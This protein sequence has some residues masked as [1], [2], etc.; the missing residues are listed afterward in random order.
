[1]TLRKRL[2]LNGGL[3]L[4][5]LV[6]ILY[7]VV[8]SIISSGFAELETQTI[9]R[10]VQ[11]VLK[12]VDATQATLNASDRDYA[13]WDDMY[14]F[15]QDG[16]AEF[17]TNNLTD[18]VFDNL[19]LNIIAVVKP[20]AEV[21]Y[22]RSY[23]LTTQSD[24]AVPE[25]LLAHLTVNDRLLAPGTPDG[26]LTGLMALPEGALLIVSHPIL[27]S[28]G[29]GPGAGML[30]MGRYLNVAEIQR[31]AETT[32]LSI[33]TY[34][35]ASPQLPQPVESIKASLS[36][37]A[38]GATRALDAETIAGYSLLTDL[39]NQPALIVQVSEARTIYQRGQASLN[40]VV[41]ALLVAGL[42]LG[43]A[44][45][46]LLDKIVL[47]RVS[48][49]STAI[50]RLDAERDLSV[51]APISGRD[52][53]SGLAISFNSMAAQLEQSV[54]TLE[55][56]V[57]LQ[58]AQLQAGAEVGRAATSILDPDRLLK[59][60]MTLITERFGFYYAAAFVLDEAGQ[61][62][63]LREASGPGD[64]A[65]LLKQSS[66]KLEIGGR[67]MISTAVTTRHPRI[68]LDV[69]TEAVR[70]ANPLLPDTRSEIALPL[71]VGDQVL[72]ALDVQSTQP[73]AFDASSAAV[74]QGMADQIAVAINNAAQY[75]RAQARTEQIAGLLAAS[76]E[77]SGQP[78]QIKL[79]ERVEDVSSSLLNADGVGLWFAIDQERLELRHTVN[80][81]P[82]DLTGRQLRIGE[83]LVG[84]VF[85]SGLIL[86]VD[87]YLAWTGRAS[88]FAD[89]PFHSAMGVP[90]MW[91][92]RVLGVLA[93]TR[94]KPGNPFTTDDENLAQLVAAQAAAALDN[95]RLRAAQQQALA[96]LDALNRRLTGEAWQVQALN[97]TL[98]Y[99]RRQLARTPQAPGRSVRIPIELRGTPIGA[100]T[101][102]DEQA[103]IF[104]DDEQAFINGI[105]QQLALALENQRLTDVAQSSAQR[106]RAIAETAD[107][108]HQ[109]TSLDAILRVA[110]NELSR[111]TGISGVGVQLGFAPDRSTGQDNHAP[112]RTQENE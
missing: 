43:V 112:D 70:F 95:I 24:V 103:R 21:V 76:L 18:S 62:A 80:V 5:G 6:L 9:S 74:L 44:S 89:A 25:G 109:P 58:T 71:I 111:I 33:S 72:G 87:D 52:E 36:P 83:G 93:I 32:Q 59:Q 79:Y 82:I 84:K 7:L 78:D 53:L 50:R 90:L 51:R 30:I 11:R 57:E 40:L 28:N 81:G 45:M 104:T 86:R 108:I 69:G 35:W 48:Q 64:V 12:A 3:L 105:T 101:L 54:E 22:I 107:K 49:L 31:L 68:A 77:L 41:A 85:E 19:R 99:E 29:D 2:L 38:P 16:N 23:D 34:E 73:A 4:A 61:W 1:M 96:D 46:L 63:N 98:T 91:Q 56:R 10:D 67:S 106:D 75:R 42:I 26:A 15:A 55:R 17:A 39:N 88:A 14:A 65:Q 60:A 13:R 100:I 20:T 27:T 47:T 8:A 110:V 97:Q 92:N 37:A 66:H 94:S 102:E